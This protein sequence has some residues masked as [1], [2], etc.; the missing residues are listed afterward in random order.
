MSG[1]IL[2]F[3]VREPW[4]LSSGISWG[5]GDTLSKLSKLA[6]PLDNKFL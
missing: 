6:F 3:E 1:D 4:N 5:T 2:S